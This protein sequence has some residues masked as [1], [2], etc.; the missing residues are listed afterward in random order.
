MQLHI[1]NLTQF[2][3]LKN[4]DFVVCNKNFKVRKTI[5]DLIEIYET[6]GRQHNKKIY[7]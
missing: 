2:Q 5:Q 7:F 3:L 6:I 1:N 4:N